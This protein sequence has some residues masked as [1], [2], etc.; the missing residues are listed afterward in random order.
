MKTGDSPVLEKA[1]V[2]KIMELV[3]DWQIANQ[4]QVKHHDLDWTNATLYSG[5]MELA[6]VSKNARYNQ[7]LLDIGSRYLWQPFYNM[8]LADDIAVSQMYLDMYKKTGDKRMLYPTMARIEFI[9]NHPSASSLN[10]DYSNYLTLERWSWCDALFMAPPVY[11]QMYNITKDIKYMD[12]MDK[13][14]KGTYNLLYNK[15]EKLF[16][17]DWSYLE[18]KEVNGKKVFWGRGNGWVMGGLVKILK[19]LPDSDPSRKF[20]DNLL[21]EMSERISGLQNKDGY[22]HASLLDPEAFPNPETSSSGFFVYALAY[23]INSGLLDRS[24]YL[25]VVSRGWKA[26]EK[27]V[28]PDG[29]LGWVQPVGQDPQKTTKEMTDVYGVGAFLFAG[30]EVY[31]L[32]E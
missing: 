14:Y 8:Y 12:F 20:Y 18:K 25:P 3:A 11:A 5:M 1:Q 31:K 28:Y 24:K 22:W 17:R 10:I 7:W 9:I 27:A 26:L 2:L 15:E 19:E 16:T 23:G 30:S 4:G 21:I 29:K 32:A 6:S 13:E